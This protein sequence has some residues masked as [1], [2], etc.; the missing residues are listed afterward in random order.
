M[1]NSPHYIGHRKRL[2]ERFRRSS[3]Q[4]EDYELLELLLGYGLPRRDT[5]P[6][7]KELLSRFG[8]LKGVLTAR[9]QELR[10]VP[11][12]GAGLELFWL[13][14]REF[15]AR[16]A[17]Q[18][19]RKRQVLSGPDAVAEAARARIGY[20]ERE[21]F[22]LALVDNK[23]R[24]IAF[25]MLG[26][27]TVDQTAVYPREVFTLALEHRASGLILVHNHPGGDPAPSAHDLELTRRLQ[28]AGAELG[29]R[30]LDHIIVAE[31]SHCSF[32]A[33]GRL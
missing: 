21:S 12:F 13:V 27:G 1:S 14:W 22:W 2:K 5:K 29:I 25:A 6:L 9:P 7:A 15:W 30:V 23:N 32:R 4:V 28:Q 18:P 16:T 3:D 8:S 10:Q 31:D 19:A 17:E 20:Q 24:L 11:Q 33:E 26:T